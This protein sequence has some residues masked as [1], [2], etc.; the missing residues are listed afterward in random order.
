MLSLLLGGLVGSLANAAHAPPP[1]L[2]GAVAT[3]AGVTLVAVA[4]LGMRA[5]SLAEEAGSGTG[6]GRLLGAHPWQT[7]LLIGVVAGVVRGSA[8]LSVGGSLASSATSAAWFFAPWALGLGLLGR[9]AV[10]AHAQPDEADDA[11]G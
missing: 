10:S 2:V 3:T 9:F 7:G 6:A 4:V 8:A 11:R 5:R 1:V